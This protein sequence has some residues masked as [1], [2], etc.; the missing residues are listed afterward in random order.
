RTSLVPGRIPAVNE[1]EFYPS[2]R[3][4]VLGLVF[5]VLVAAWAALILVQHHGLHH[6]GYQDG[7]LLVIVPILGVVVWNRLRQTARGNPRLRISGDG[8]EG[9]FGLIR[10][11][12][13]E[14]VETPFKVSYPSTGRRLVIRLKPGARIM[15]TSREFAAGVGI[16][17]DKVEDDRV[18]I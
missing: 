10:W 11:S 8:V 1:V 6:I 3:G 5:A 17:L 4:T 2:R 13:I 16:S 15:P 14:A 7:K 12:D 18:V 9:T